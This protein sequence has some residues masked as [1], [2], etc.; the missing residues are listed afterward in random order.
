M[1][2]FRSA[3]WLLLALLV[4]VIPASSH[5]QFSLSISVGFA[6]PELPVYEQPVCPEPNLMWM[7]GYWAYSNDDGDY[8]WVPGAW[9]PAPYQG[10]LWTPPY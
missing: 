2:L 7:P 10:A 3:R 4:S 5:A 9:V 1:Q 6:P 8:Y